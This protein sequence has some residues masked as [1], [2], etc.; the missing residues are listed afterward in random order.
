MNW[1]EFEKNTAKEHGRR[2]LD[3][4]LKNES[5][6]VYEGFRWLKVDDRTKVLVPC[7]KNGNPTEKGRRILESVKKIC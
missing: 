6:K 4:L 7:D 1:V 3:K 2:I 5:K